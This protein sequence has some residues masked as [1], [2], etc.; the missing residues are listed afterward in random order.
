MKKQKIIRMLIAVCIIAFSSVCFSAA[1]VTQQLA[2]TSQQSSQLLA[3]VGQKCRL[4]LRNGILV[5]GTLWDFDNVSVT[6]KVKKGLLYSKTERHEISK[7]DYFEDASGN[8]I[9]FGGSAGGAGKK[10]PATLIFSMDDTEEQASDSETEA[11]LPALSGSGQD[12]HVDSEE[13]ALQST[14]RILDEKKEQLQTSPASPVEEKAEFGS[15]K[16]RGGRRSTAVATSK[17][18]A[19]ETAQMQ[20]RKPEE[21][22]SGSRLSPTTPLVKGDEGKKGASGKQFRKQRKIT[23]NT[24]GTKGDTQK[25]LRRA[26]S[27][28]VP[29]TPETKKMRILRYQTLILF[30]VVVFIALM[31]IFSRA[32]GMKSSAYSKLSLFPSKLVK[33]NGRYGI[34][35]QGADD[36]VKVDDIIRLYHKVGKKILFRGMVKVKKVADNYS[37]VEVIKRKKGTRLQVGDVGFRDRNFVATA[38]KRLR[39]WT[40]H[41]LNKLGKR[42]LLTAQELDVNEEEPTIAFGVD[43]DEAT[44]KM[45]ENAERKVKRKAKKSPAKKSAS[46]KGTKGVGFGID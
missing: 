26:E 4:T 30:G 34:I 22:K 6:V 7:V 2:I 37:A 3:L 45:Q 13:K 39:I 44:T 35:D 1:P 16:D 10:P 25:K 14:L 21:K 23:Q 29:V 19:T 20:D 24:K 33:M 38:V 40:S 18:A 12:S 43:Q 11:G 27:T 5:S 31:M 15:D 9:Y 41:T 8:K 36:G 32:I 42:I 46:S 28:Y 17:E